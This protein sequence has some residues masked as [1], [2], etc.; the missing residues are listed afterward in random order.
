MQGSLVQP[1]LML[2]AQRDESTHPEKVPRLPLLSIKAVS[3]LLTHLKF[4]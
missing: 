2:A 3:D 1:L 4:R